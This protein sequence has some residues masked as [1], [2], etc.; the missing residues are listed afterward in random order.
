MQECVFLIADV[1]KRSVKARHELFDLSEVYVAYG[2]GQGAV[3]LLERHQ[4]AVLEKRYR[5][6]AGLYVNDKF[7]FHYY[8][9]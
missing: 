5:H 8:L 2:I 1:H 4:A 3:L 9:G 7:A 6:F